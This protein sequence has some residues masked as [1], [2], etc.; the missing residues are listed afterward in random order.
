MPDY[1]I[2]L[3]V[4]AT[5]PAGTVGYCPQYAMANVNMV[6][7]TV[8][9]QGGHGAYPH[10]TKDPVVLASQ[11]ILNLQTIVSRE[12]SPLEPAVVTVGSIHGGTKGNIISDEVMLE[13]TLRSYSDE[14]RQ[15]LIDKIRRICA[16][17]AQAAGLPPELYPEVE[18][19]DEETPSVY[20][21]PALTARL[22]EAFEAALT[23]ENVQTLSP[24]MGGE[25]FARYGRTPEQVPIH[26]FWLG[27]ISPEKIAQAKAGEIELPSL[28]SPHYAPLPEPSILTGVQAMSAAVL[29]LLGEE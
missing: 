22:G 10:T 21:D 11:I 24:V 25:D 26:L 8:H 1:A 2:A 27:T 16:G 9:G 6:N 19:L 5:L 14:V 13:L 12:I 28:H 23:E 18:V 17:Q 4:S 29:E 7:L 3:H 15:A 20:N